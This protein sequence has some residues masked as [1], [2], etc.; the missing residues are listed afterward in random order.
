MRYFAAA[1]LFLMAWHVNTIDGFTM[2]TMPSGLRHVDVLATGYNANDGQE[3]CH[4]VSGKWVCGDRVYDGTGAP[5]VG[6]I[7]VSHDM[8]QLMGH[9]VWVNGW[10]YVVRDL[11]PNAWMGQVYRHRIDI[12]FGTPQAAIRWGQKKVTMFIEE[13]LYSG[14]MFYGQNYRA[15]EGT[16]TPGIPCFDSVMGLEEHSVG[17]GGARVLLSGNCVP[18]GSFRQVLDPMG[19]Q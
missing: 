18:T 10:K 6:T 5:Y 15:V 4:T 9:Y 7:A 11:M 2:D 12:Y 1:V 19:T 14:A 3:P 17:R 13:T 8:I 16:P